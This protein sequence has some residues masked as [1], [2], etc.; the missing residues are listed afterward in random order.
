MRKLSAWQLLSE[1]HALKG[2]DSIVKTN[3]SL[4][5]ERRKDA[6]LMTQ[7]VQLKP[8]RKKTRT[9]GK[10]EEEKRRKGID[11]GSKTLNVLVFTGIEDNS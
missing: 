3:E 9:G 8:K 6:K 7:E 1:S 4:K 10:E 2:E 5:R 11:I